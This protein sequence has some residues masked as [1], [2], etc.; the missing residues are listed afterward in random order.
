MSFLE[1]V[2]LCDNFSVRKARAT[3]DSERL[4]PWA[5]S[6]APTSPVIGL[7]RPAIVDLLRSENER[8]NSP[9]IWDIPAQLDAPNARISFHSRIDTPGR[10]TA[11]MKEMCERWRDTGL[12]PDVIGPQ[13]WRAEMYSV[14]ANPFGAHD[15]ILDGTGNYAL[16]IERA[17]CALFGTITYGVHM[18]IYED[19]EDIRMW[20]PT[21]AKTK[22]TW[23]GFLDNSVAGG[24]PSGTGIFEAI[25]K[26]AMEEASIAED[27]V[28]KHAKCV[29]C[30][31]YF[32]QTD[33]GWLQPEIEYL[34]ELVIPEGADPTPFRPEP[35]DGEVESFE[36]LPMDTIIQEMRLGK[37]KPNCALVIIDLLIRKGRIVP[38][39]EPDFVHIMTRLHGNFDYDLW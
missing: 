12:Y 5:L 29:G 30:L 11:V 20:V 1:I 39:N 6:S 22:Q 2:A 36:L 14:Y 3:T 27:I 16:E 37:F 34:Y 21:R 9:Q 8:L 32:Y 19:G 38:D 31:S 28:R 18:S 17:A 23:P 4:V 24:I 15:H 10:R 26:E 33:A 13:K 35:L 7:L 25:V